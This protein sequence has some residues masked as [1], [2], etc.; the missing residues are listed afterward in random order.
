MTNDVRLEVWRADRRAPLREGACTPPAG[1]LSSRHVVVAFRQFVFAAV[2][3][4]SARG[5]AEAAPKGQRAR[6]RADLHRPHGG[7]GLG[8]RA[9]LVRSARRSLWT[10]LA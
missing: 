6:L 9:R 8:E 5:D 3:Q 4:T 10:V 2:L 7:R 1:D